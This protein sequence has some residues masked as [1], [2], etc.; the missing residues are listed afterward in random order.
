[1]SIIYEPA[2]KAREYSP[3]AAN[4]YIGCNHKCLYCYGPNIR[5]CSIENFNPY[6]RRNIL[7]ELKKDCKKFYRTDKNVLLCF[8][9]DPYNEIDDTENIT[10]K[11]LELFLEN[12][13]PAAIL[14]K[15]GIKALKNID[16]YKK[17]GEHIKV[18]ATLTMDNSQD[19]KEWEPGAAMPCER[20]EMLKELKENNIKTWASFEPVIDP[21][22]SINMIKK[23]L[24][25]VDIYKIGKINNFRGIDKKINWTDFLEKA[26]TILRENKKP[27]YIKHDLRQ[28]AP[29]IKL[30][31]NEVNYDEFN[32]PCFPQ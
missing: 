10:R 24:P 27:F 13:I 17:F 20:I 14:T 3:L 31:G 5:R 4:I 19:S 29:S 15:A 22:Q 23:T 9:S 25:Y 8:M 21:E 1:M 6:I 28:S 16:I 7:Q 26:V 32:L 30:Y 12:K 11:A 18:G 2:G